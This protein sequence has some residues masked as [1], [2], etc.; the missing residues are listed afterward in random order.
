MSGKVDILFLAKNRR[1]FTEQALMALRANTNWGLVKSLTLWDDGSEDGTRAL[2]AHVSDFHIAIKC[3]VFFR[4]TNIGGP[5]TIAYRHAQESTAEFVAKTD[6][7]CMVPPGWLDEGFALMDANPEL[8]VLALEDPVQEPTIIL[9]R[10]PQPIHRVRTVSSW[11]GGIY[12]ARRRVYEGRQAPRSGRDLKQPGSAGLGYWWGW[13]QWLEGNGVRCAWIEPPLPVFLLDRLPFEPWLS[14][15][16]EYEAKGWQRPWQK[17]DP[18]KH[19]YLWEWAK[20]EA[21][22]A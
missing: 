1:R 22:H 4:A 3:P 12:L 7:D 17:Y 5:V 8:E 20:L 16:A 11:V 14:L 9:S 15:S 21:T 10:V 18:E 6:N 13:P 19:A 2:L